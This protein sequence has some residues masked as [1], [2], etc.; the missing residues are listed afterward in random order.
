MTTTRTHP[1]PAAPS[2]GSGP[3]VPR[4]AE[5]VPVAVLGISFGA[6]A[7]I[8]PNAV[9]DLFSGTQAVLVTL[10][11]VTGWLLLSRL[12]LPRLIRN[13]W[14]R[15][16][17]L[18]AL[19]VAVVVALVLPTVVDKKVVE[20]LPDSSRDDSAT[21]VEPDAPEAPAQP[22][23]S[24]E[25]LTIGTGTLRGIDHD[26]T[27][28][29]VLY[30]R[31]DGTFIVG[32]EDID[33]EPGPDYKVYIVPGQNREEPG[34]N[35]ILLSDLRGNQGTQFYDVPAGTNV[36]AGEWTVLIWCRSFAVPI[37]NSTPA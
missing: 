22:M 19:A 6:M 27:G 14:A 21:A 2:P 20:A 18:S 26:A 24:T 15:V 29:A 13:G 10:G 17:V 23:T 1:T 8:R 12:I 4:W 5:L 35:G 37:A 3:S 11:L 25:P 7:A 31:S 36:V 30:Q 33:V 9:R 34:D 28:S 16:G 32:L